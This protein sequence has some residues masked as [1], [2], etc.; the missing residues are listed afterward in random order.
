MNEVFCN[1]LSL[2]M[3]GLNISNDNFCQWTYYKRQKTTGKWYQMVKSN[4]IK[5]VMKTKM[6][7]HHYTLCMHVA[8]PQ[9]YNNDNY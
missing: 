3:R 8:F 7:V 1:L 2:N 5:N 4:N 6:H 9:I